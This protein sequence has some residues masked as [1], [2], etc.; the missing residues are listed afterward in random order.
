MGIIRQL[1]SAILNGLIAGALTPLMKSLGALLVG[2][3]GGGGGMSAMAPLAMAVATLDTGGSILTSG[4]VYA[5]SGE[6]VQPAQVG[7][8]DS[9]GGARGLTMNITFDGAICPHCADQLTDTI[10]NSII[11][12]TRRA[13]GRL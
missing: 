4:L 3:G 10:A 8:L 13:G 5:H 11:K 1:E 7:P 12:G 2:I 6:V 9:G